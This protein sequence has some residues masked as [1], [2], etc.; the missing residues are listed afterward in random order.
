[1]T[2]TFDE[3]WQLLYGEDHELSM[4]QAKE[5]FYSMT[6]VEMLKA[7]YLCI[8]WT[9]EELKGTD[10]DTIRDIA[11]LAGEEAIVDMKSTL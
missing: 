6:P 5:A 11:V 2:K 7:G 3:E 8:F 1:M 9:P 10:P 4:K